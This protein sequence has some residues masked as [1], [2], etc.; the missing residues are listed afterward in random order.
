M[1]VFEARSAIGLPAVEVFRWHARPGAFL[2]LSPPWNRVEV[3]DARGGIENGARLVLRLGT[4][5]LALTWV[6]VHRGYEEGRR[7]VDVQESGP[8]AEWVHEHRFEDTAPGRSEVVD[9]IDYTIPFGRL[10]ELAAGPFVGKRLERVFRY[11]G[12]LTADDLARHAP[13]LSQAPL[14]VAISGA[15]GLIGSQL[16]AFLTTG[17]HEVLRFARGKTAKAGEIA[18]NPASGRIDHEAL[19]GMD[20]VVHLAGESI[21]QGRWTEARKA[22][23]AASRVKGTTLLAEALAVLRTPPRVFLSASAIGYYGDRGVSRV[24]ETVS[25]GTGF[26]AGVAKRWEEAT[27]PARAAGIRTVNMRFGVILTSRGGALAK[28]LLPFKLGAGG[29]IGDGRQGFSW[30]ALDDAIY[31]IHHLMRNDDLRGPVNV[32]APEPLP[33]AAFAKALGRTV[34]RPAVVPLPAIV[35]RKLFG[36]MGEEVLLAGQFVTPAALRRSGFVWS[37]P[38]LD[39]ALTR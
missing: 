5:P 12:R 2:R 34:N 18:W 4:P 25:P 3:I 33:Q 16:A 19:E 15:S 13:Y 1:A 8:F 31:A 32:V 29:P 39:E 27:E 17:G 35:V 11:R 20:A 6:A 26:L 24:D 14:R 36:Q 37:V 7:F 22:E 9:R 38:S 28:M 30:I 10:G 21:A 23:I